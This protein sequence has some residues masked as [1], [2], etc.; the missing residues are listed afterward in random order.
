MS[1]LLIVWQN[2]V[3]KCVAQHFTFEVAVL[4]CNNSIKPLCGN[5]HI[6]HLESKTQ[7]CLQENG[8]N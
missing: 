2:Q 5:L 8:M 4:G 7:E 1:L 6:K 3:P